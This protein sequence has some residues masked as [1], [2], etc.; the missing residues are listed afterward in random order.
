[1]TLVQRKGNWLSA[2]IGDEL[3]MMSAE[4]GAYLGLS[5]V[6]ARIW[7]LIETPRDIEDIFAQLT[8]EFEV[9]LETCRAE[10]T[11]FLQE[12]ASNGAVEMDPQPGR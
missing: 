1:M 7:E 4:R 8:G 12:L 2:M 9:E 11:Q 5:S 3:V 6:G 10:V